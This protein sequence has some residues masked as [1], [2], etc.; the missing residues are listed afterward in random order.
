MCQD[1]RGALCSH[2][3]NEHAVWARLCEWGDGGNVCPFQTFHSVAAALPA[4]MQRLEF[5]FS[6]DVSKCGCHFP[7]AELKAEV[8]VPFGGC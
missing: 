3:D 1:S 6:A 7:W 5:G 4:V 2:G 8:G